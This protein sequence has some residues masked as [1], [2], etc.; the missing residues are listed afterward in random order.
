MLRFSVCSWY[1]KFLLRSQLY[2]LVVPPDYEM[3]ATVCAKDVEWI[4]CE[5]VIKTEPMVWL[6]R[7]INKLT[8]KILSATK[9]TRKKT[10]QE[11]FR[12]RKAIEQPV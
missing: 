9:R 3:V 8:E 1:F 10:T 2:V 4:E 7:E 11:N 12:H 5:H 6:D